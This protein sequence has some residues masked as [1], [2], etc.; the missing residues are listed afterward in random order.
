MEHHEH[1]LRLDKSGCGT[2]EMWKDTDHGRI[3]VF[4]QERAS[5]FD[6]EGAA[7]ERAFQLTRDED[8]LGERTFD[9]RK[10]SQ[11]ES[12]FSTYARR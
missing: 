7:T 1:P 4:V 9:Q 2:A 8:R 12:R 5:V 11:F 10:L 6:I 3:G